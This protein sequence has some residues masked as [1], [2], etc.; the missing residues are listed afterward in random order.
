MS[1]VPLLFNLLLHPLESCMGFFYAASRC[2]LI[3]VVLPEEKKTVGGDKCPS[4]TQLYDGRRS[5]T[6]VE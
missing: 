4:G 1:A 2:G 6:L 5:S 3:L